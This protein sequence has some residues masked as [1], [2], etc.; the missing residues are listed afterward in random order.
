MYRNIYYSVDPDTKLG[1]I[2]LFTWDADGEPLAIDQVHRSRVI[3]TV[4]YKTHH[5]SIFGEYV[6]VKEF[7]NTYE[8]SKFLKANKHLRILECAR[9]EV[10]FL[11]DTYINDYEREDFQK[12]PLYVLTLDIEIAVEAEFPV[13]DK[14]EYPVNVITIHDS[15]NG[16][17]ITWCQGPAK[18]VTDRKDVDIRQF[19]SE[20]TLLKDFQLWYIDNTPDVITGWNS[21]YFD[22]PY[23]INRYNKVFD[24]EDEAQFFSPVQVIKK[25]EP[26]LDKPDEEYRLEFDIKGVSQLDYLFLVK[27]FNSNI[28]YRSYQLKDVAA[29]ELEDTKITYEGLFKNFWKLDFCKFVNYNIR[30]T[31]LVVFLNDKFRFIELAR[32]MCNSGLTEYESIYYSI[33]YIINSLAAYS[34]KSRQQYFPTYTLRDN[35]KFEQYEGAHVKIPDAGFYKEG[36]CHIDVSSLY[37]NII[38]ALNLSPETKF[39]KLVRDDFTGKLEIRTKNNSIPLTEE[40]LKNL[41]ETKFTKSANNILFLKHSEMKGVMAEFVERMYQQR[42]DFRSLAKKVKKEKE[43]LEAVDESQ[44]DKAKITELEKRITLLDLSIV[45]IKN[46]LNSIYGFMG[47]KF[48]S[49]YDTDLAEAI[50]KTGQMIIMKSFDLID[51]KLRA[52]DPSKPNYVIAGDTDSS[53]FDCSPITKKYH[54]ENTSKISK[55]TVKD[56]CKELN[57]FVEEINQLCAKHVTDQ[58]HTK[59]GNRIEFK[60][61]TFSLEAFFFA[62]KR[63]ILHILDKEGVAKDEFKYVGVEVKRKDLPEKIAKKLEFLYDK[64][65]KDRWGYDQFREYM[66]KVWD[67]YQLMD[68][69]DIAAYKGYRTEKEELSYMVSEGGSGIQVRAKTYYNQI[70][71][72][73]KLEEK[74]DLI[75]VGDKVRYTYISDENQYRIDVIGF[76]ELCPEEFKGM[77][78]VDY[79]TMFEKSLSNAV[80]SLCKAMGWHKFRLNDVSAACDISKL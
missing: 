69:N 49:I 46:F 65:C 76:K 25:I 67:E 75:R 78:C 3:H 47:S 68:I 21:L 20:V 52:L 36:V 80:L 42:V 54:N 12:N 64:I 10:E 43:E 1:T 18:V 24:N 44:R 28:N 31:E 23:L 71:K 62:K 16:K 33:P 7:N 48:S 4:P 60:R 9:P 79:K 22:L 8:R 27:K 35:K 37:P 15:R 11:R 34:L 5:K 6:A 66:I 32:K 53:F 61:E 41:L 73:M 38:V 72:D 40:Q 63:Y 45:N 77:F 29:E 2:K 70:I 13:P 17:F 58:C 14:A 30:D 55:K 39:G 74:Y 50:T 59:Y 26:R 57:V 56:L 19:D 51:D